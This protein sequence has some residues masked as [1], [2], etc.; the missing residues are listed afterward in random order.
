MPTNRTSIEQQLN[1]ANIAIN[2]ALSEPSL[3]AALAG[4][5]Y[6]A[7][8]LRQGRVLREQALV[9]YQQQKSAYGDLQTSNDI[10]AAALALAEA[11]YMRYVK[12]ARVAL[13]DERGAQH[14]LSMAGQRKRPQAAR[15]AQTQQFYANALSDTAILGKLAAFGITQAMLA[16]GQRQLDAV[17][18][19]DAVRRQHQGAAREATR[20]RDAALA[21]LGYWMRDFMQVARVALRDRPQ[22]LQMLG[23]NA[24]AA[25]PAARPPASSATNVE[26]PVVENA[27]PPADSR[28]LTVEDHAVRSTATRR[29]GTKI[30]AVSE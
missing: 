7:E 23:A 24:S 30:A 1:L 3:A 20:A 22:L 19:G 9:F 4:F 15:L 18:Q 12:V 14:K 29:N 6:T 2:N 28:P 17:A 11:T 21:A 26:T 5:G 10:Y 8:R 16:A 13:E 27:A 25:R